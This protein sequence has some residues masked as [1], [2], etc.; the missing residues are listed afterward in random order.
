MKSVL[1]GPDQC[2]EVKQIHI[3]EPIEGHF[4]DYNGKAATQ[5]FVRGLRDGAFPNLQAIVVALGT[6]EVVRENDFTR[7]LVNVLRNEAP[8]TANLLHVNMYCSD[9]MKRA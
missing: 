3:Y 7:E 6:N 1:N 9:E 5:S 8:C 2:E 4:V